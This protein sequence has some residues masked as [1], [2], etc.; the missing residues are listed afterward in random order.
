MLQRQ[1]FLPD[2]SVISLCY[3]CAISMISPCYFCD[4]SVFSIYGIHVSWFFEKGVRASGARHTEPRFSGVTA[5]GALAEARKQLSGVT[6]PI[7][8]SDTSSNFNI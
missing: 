5:H 7:P 2:I 4:I 6:A 8:K 3:L 1:F